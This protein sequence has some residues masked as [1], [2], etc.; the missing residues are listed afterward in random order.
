MYTLAQDDGAEAGGVDRRTL[1]RNGAGFAVALPTMFALDTVRAFAQT[2]DEANAIIRSLAPMRGLNVTPGYRPQRREEVRI[3]STIV[4]VDPGRA[5][6][7]EVYFE[8]DSARVT[9]SAARQLVALGRAL[10]SPTLAPYRYLI[11]GHT[12]AVGSDEYNFDLSRRRAAAVRDYLVST[13]PIDP[14]RLM[15]VG[16]G[17]RRLKQ[18]RFPRAAVNRRVEVLLVVP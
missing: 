7:L 8:Y 17:F 4:Y 11:A 14:G 13:F 6:S 9:P 10:S 1:L 2:A 16:F 3:D 12:D 15:V 18:P 5:V